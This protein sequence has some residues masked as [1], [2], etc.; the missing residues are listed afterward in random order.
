MT[1][2]DKIKV[3]SINVNG[4]RARENQLRKFISEQGENQIIAISDTRLSES[5]VVKDIDKFSLLRTDKERHCQMA[6][7]GG[8]GLIVPKSWSCLKISLKC[9]GDHIEAIAAIILPIGQ[10]CQPLKIMGLYNHPGH[11]IPQQLLT[12]FKNITFNGKNLPGLITGD[13]NSPHVV[14]GSRTTNEF[15]SK[16]VQILNQ[17][18]LIFLN[19]GSPTY[20]SNSTGLENILDLSIGNSLMSPFVESC[21]VSGDVGSD[22]FPL[23]TVLTFKI[24]PVRKKKVDMKLWARTVDNQMENYDAS[25]NIDQNIEQINRIF[26]ESYEISFISTKPKRRNLPLEIRQNISL[27]KSLLRSRQKASTEFSKKILT[28]Q[29]NRYNHLVKQQL[30]DYDDQQLEKIAEGIC[31]ADNTNRMWKIFNTYKN[32]YKDIEEP[33]APLLLPDGSYTANNKEKCDEFARYLK[34]VHQTPD[35]PFF[36]NLFKQNIEEEI[37][38]H[39]VEVDNGGAVGPIDLQSMRR[40]LDE[41]KKGSAAGEDTISYDILKLCSDCTLLKVCHLF[42]QCISLNVFPNAWKQAKVIMLPKPGRDKYQSCNYRPISLISCMGKTYERH[43]YNQLMH[44]L[45]ELDFM[46]PNQAGFMKGR[47]AQEHIFRLAQDVSNGFKKRHCTLA[48]FVDV[49]A[50][51]DAVWQAGLKHTIK[52]MGLSKQMTNI[53]F[54][55]LSNRTLK[56]FI[57]ELWSEEVRLGAGT[58]QGSFLSPILYCIFVNSIT[59]IFDAD[60]LTPSQYADDVGIWSTASD[61]ATAAKNITEGVNKL[62]AWCRTW[63]V[64]L[65]PIKS[66]LILFSKCPRHGKEIEENGLS[67]KLFGS[68]IPVV[69]EAEFLGVTFDSRLT[70]EPQTKKVTTRAYQRLNLLRTI[71]TMSSKHNPEM[72]MTLYQS[73]IRPI[74]EYSSICSITAAECHTDKLQLI[75]NQ[76]LRVILKTPAYVATKDLHDASGLVPIKSHLIEIGSKR[77]N[78]FIKNSPIVGKSIQD[79][80]RVKHIKENASP[81]DII[82]IKP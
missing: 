2:A 1:F 72:L 53:L 39:K 27:R 74:F 66:K 79:Y 17:E 52:N 21:Y 41:T 70:W 37:L 40:L 11:Y 4:F 48:L 42:N 13:F 7:A 16:L 14:F 57:D 60:K 77:I 12:E 26:K 5:T 8:V 38:R 73:I 25:E 63:H 62:E 29:Y 28:K 67:I 32:R 45:K 49:K 3:I 82:N 43:I 22:H 30:R 80:N 44:E 55:F 19:N 59:K 34:S 6:T 78:S 9:T 56:V 50:A 35:S 31:N 75:Q 54:S 47:S 69:T 58:P 71:S 36:D 51:F 10:N 76:S 68:L 23:I 64:T 65:S 81:L 20:F 15:G 61:V 24:I 46:S 18:E 33:E